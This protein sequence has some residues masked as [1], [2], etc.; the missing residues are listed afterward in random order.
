MVVVAEAGTCNAEVLWVGSSESG[1]SAE[2]KEAENTAAIVCWPAIVFI[3]FFCGIFTFSF[4][5]F[6]EKKQDL[7]RSTM[8]TQTPS[9]IKRWPPLKVF[10]ITA[11]GVCCLY[12]HT[13]RPLDDKIL[14]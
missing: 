14:T 10:F 3:F 2:V 7:V 11:T 13:A 9:I 6:L 8:C 12:F 4:F 1:W 5:C